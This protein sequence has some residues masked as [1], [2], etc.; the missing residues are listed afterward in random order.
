VAEPQAKWVRPS[1]RSSRVAYRN[2]VPDEKIMEHTRRR[3]LTTMR[4]YV[5]RAKVSKSS[6]AEEIGL[7]RYR[8]LN[9]GLLN[10]LV[11]KL[12]K[13]PGMR[14][15]GCVIA[16]DFQADVHGGSVQLLG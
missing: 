3:S 12:S 13:V 5:Q 2:G 7:L 9:V 11:I 14:K 6:P 15:I 10:V 8:I 16:H 1:Q 4:S